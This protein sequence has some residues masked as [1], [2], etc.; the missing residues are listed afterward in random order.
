MR[1]KITEDATL[2]EI[3]K[4]PGAKKTLAKYN[5]PCLS[6]PMAEFELA[7]LKIGQVC[8]MYDID[9]GKLLKEL[10][11]VYPRT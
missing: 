11:E 4:L 2:V 9:V 5:L 7:N 1:N 6:C 3:F 10:N 8:E